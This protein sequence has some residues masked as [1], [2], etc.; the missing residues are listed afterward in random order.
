MGKG[1]PQPQN[2]RL[3][4]HPQVIKY[5]QDTREA[6][7]WHLCGLKIPDEYKSS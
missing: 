1:I 2:R 7:F 5:F 6:E 4:I 3:K